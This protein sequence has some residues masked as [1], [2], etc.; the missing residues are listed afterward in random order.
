[1]LRRGH[2]DADTYA[3]PRTE[4]SMELDLCG[5]EEDAIVIWLEE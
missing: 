3:F 1:M 2:T 5:V 4:V